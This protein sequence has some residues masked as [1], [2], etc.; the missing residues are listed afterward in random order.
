MIKTTVHYSSVPYFDLFF[1]FIGDGL[2]LA[3]N[4][5]CYKPTRPLFEP[6]KI[7]KT[8]ISCDLSIA[9]LNCKLKIWNV[10]E[11]YHL[12]DKASHLIKHNTKKLKKLQ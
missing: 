6:Y 2:A 7:L 10:F 4:I 9:C 8:A 1:H 12:I 3:L 5:F 11:I